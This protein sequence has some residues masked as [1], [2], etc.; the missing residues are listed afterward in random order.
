MMSIDIQQKVVTETDSVTFLSQNPLK[1]RH[2][3]ATNRI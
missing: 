3:V 2:S 1:M